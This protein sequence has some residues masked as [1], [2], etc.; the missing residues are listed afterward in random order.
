MET[1]RWLNKITS[2]HCMLH[3]KSSGINPN[4]LKLDS[5]SRPKYYLLGYGKLSFVLFYVFNAL[6]RPSKI[7]QLVFWRTSDD[8]SIIRKSLHAYVNN[9]RG[10]AN[11][12][13]SM[14]QR[15]AS[16][17]S[18][19]SLQLRAA[20]QKSNYCWQVYCATLAAQNS[21]SNRTRSKVSSP[22]FS[23]IFSNSIFRS[24]AG[25]SLTVWN[26]DGRF[27]E[28]I[29]GKNELPPAS[30]GIQMSLRRMP[31]KRFGLLERQNLW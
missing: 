5:K 2:S 25:P 13:A 14:S 22:P 20:L 17:R 21:I 1:S 3:E 27:K 26:K 12:V 15:G 10:T 11:Q 4:F 24:V 8:D 31:G 30:T 16:E 18:W 19:P 23:C 9:G 28:R 7:K 29:Y 6:F